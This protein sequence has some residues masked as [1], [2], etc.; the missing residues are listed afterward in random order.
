MENDKLYLCMKTTG[1]DLVPFYEIN[2]S[3]FSTKKD[4]GG[5]VFNM[6]VLISNINTTRFEEKTKKLKNEEKMD[7]DQPNLNEEPISVD[8]EQTLE[9]TEMEQGGT[10]LNNEHGGINIK[11][12]EGERFL[13]TCDLEDSILK[14]IHK[15]DY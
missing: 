14:Y 3:F 4:K 6:D 7:F 10:E 15:K 13:P 1:G 2:G 11:A 12:K 5:S 8:N 9:E